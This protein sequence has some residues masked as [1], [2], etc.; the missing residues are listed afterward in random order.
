MSGERSSICRNSVPKEIQVDGISGDGHH[1]VTLTAYD[2][3]LES[4]KASHLEP[5]STTKDLSHEG[6][7]FPS[8]PG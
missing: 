6:H 8:M 3:S 4:W 1:T 7:K 5:Q 2:R